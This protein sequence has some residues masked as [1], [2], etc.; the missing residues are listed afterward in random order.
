MQTA[1]NLLNSP[2]YFRCDRYLCTMHKDHC[3]IDDDQCKGCP[4]YRAPERG[5][6]TVKP[7]KMHGMWPMRFGRATKFDPALVPEGWKRC[8]HCL[9]PKPMT[10]FYVDPQMRDN[11]KSWCKA[12]CIA[13]TIASRLKHPKTRLPKAKTR[14]PYKRKKI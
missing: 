13:L 7:P 8:T 10:D 5:T 9:I 14:M 3:P 1:E 11:R 6:E 12:C 4:E 2:D